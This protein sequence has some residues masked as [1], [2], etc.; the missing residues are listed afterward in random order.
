M[1]GARAREGASLAR[2]GVER[3]ASLLPPPPPPPCGV[4]GPRRDAGAELVPGFSAAPRSP[5]PEGRGCGWLWGAPIRIPPWSGEIWS[6]TSSRN[7]RDAPG[8][9]SPAAAVSKA[10]ESHRQPLPKENPRPCLHLRPPPARPGPNCGVQEPEERRSRYLDSAR[11]L[12]AAH[13]PPDKKTEAQNWS[14]TC[15]KSNRPRQW[16]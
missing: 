7:Q 1:V 16:S 13:L 15:S 3:T 9:P 5:R 14:V 11:R 2:W 8:A 10:P 12:A 6:M 4:K